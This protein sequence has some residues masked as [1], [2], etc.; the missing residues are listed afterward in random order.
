MNLNR[1]INCICVTFT[2]LVFSLFSGQSNV[3][4]DEE[5]LSI[6]KV[7][8]INGQSIDEIQS[9]KTFDIEI[10]ITGFSEQTDDMIPFDAVLL[11][12]TS[13]SMYESKLNKA[14]SAAKK[15]VNLVKTAVESGDVQGIKIG[16]VTY[17]DDAK[18]ISNLSEDYDLLL[19]SI[20]NIERGVQTN[21]QEGM[22][23]AHSLLDLGSNYNRYCIFLTDGFPEPA[24]IEGINQLDEIYGP[25]LHEAVKKSIGY[26][27]VGIGGG[28]DIGIIQLY[29]IFTGGV[30]RLYET[31]A[32]YALLYEEFFEEISHT[33]ITSN[34]RL[35]EKL[36]TDCVEYIMGSFDTSD[37]VIPPGFDEEQAFA[38]T[39]EINIELG[40]IP[41][42]IIRSISFKVKA[43][44]CLPVDAPLGEYV[45]IHPNKGTS[46]VDYS[47]GIFPKQ[48]ELPPLSLKC[49][50]PE[51]VV[52]EKDFV[53]EDNEVHISIKSN[54]FPEFGIDN[55]VRNITVF[56][57]LSNQYHYINNTANPG[58]SFFIPG[59]ITDLLIWK[60]PVLS[61]QEEKVLKFN[62]ELR[63]YIPQDGSDL[64]INARKEP[65]LFDSYAEMTFPDGEEKKLYIPQKI[66]NVAV[67]ENLPQGR[68]NIYIQS[69]TSLNEYLN[70][71]PYLPSAEEIMNVYESGLAQNWPLSV[72][73]FAQYESP[74]IWIDS[75]ENGFV[76]DWSNITQISEH[77]DNAKFSAPGPGQ[78]LLGIRAQGDLFYRTRRNRIC[79]QLTNTGMP[80]PNSV[81]R[82]LKILMKNYLT[83]IP[84][85]ELVKEI[86]IPANIQRNGSVIVSAQLFETNPIPS[87]YLQ[88]L[89]PIFLDIWTADIKVVALP[90]ENEKHTN[91]NVSYEKILVIE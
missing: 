26:Y 61:P 52:I 73:I 63:A 15:F 84:T 48:K 22:H 27:S 59:R 13:H 54:Y 17:S 37:Q 47:Y 68:P 18:I 30:I 12:D 5:D 33:L 85:W 19:S 21:M 66:V 72:N 76:S 11:I 36:D 90:C 88:R 82:G 77:M 9:G 64:Y 56:E 60:I 2:C 89:Y 6:T 7:A 31:S 35:N 50:P 62:V 25:L 38:N 55:S 8:T 28:V 78:R 32:D 71:P 53:E 4:A 16:I 23:V 3:L 40:R 57:A 49:F 42:N 14:K 91:N 44:Q 43:K 81:S 20:D 69:S 29:A 70:P 10:H 87:K 65:E 39:G 34:V 24:I 1:S 58:T 45:L 46:K 41:N 79:V 67:L 86:D 74:Y 83:Q 51:A 75:R 80:N